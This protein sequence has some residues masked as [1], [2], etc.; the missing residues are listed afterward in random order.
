MFIFVLYKISIPYEL[1]KVKDC[2][3]EGKLIAKCR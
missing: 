2:F 1:E 3:V